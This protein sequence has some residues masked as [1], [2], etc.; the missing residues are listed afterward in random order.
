[1]KFKFLL[2][3]SKED[4]I[5]SIFSRGT[6]GY[7]GPTLFLDH[8]QGNKEI[9]VRCNTSKH[10]KKDAIYIRITKN[11]VDIYSLNDPNNEKIALDI[12]K[13]IE[14]FLNSEPSVDTKVWD[15]LWLDF[16][17]AKR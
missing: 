11:D 16:F 4:V 8:Y 1:M 5:G 15:Y 7:T 14:S 12:A 2:N 13:N 17:K 9:V 3:E 10:S 6:Y